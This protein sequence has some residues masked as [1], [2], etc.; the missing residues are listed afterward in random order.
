MQDFLQIFQKTLNSFDFKPHESALLEDPNGRFAYKRFFSK[1]EIPSNSDPKGRRELTF[2]DWVRYDASLLPIHLPN[3]SWYRARLKIRSILKHFRPGEL[4]FTNGSSSEPL[5]GRQSIVHKLLLHKWEI[6]PDCVDL[7]CSLAIRDHAFIRAAK[8]RVR[9]SLGA[10]Y[11]ETVRRIFSYRRSPD[12]VKQY[13]LRYCLSPR[14]ASRWGCVPKNNTIDR[15]IDLQPFCNML[16]QRAIGVGLRDLIRK[17]FDVDLLSSQSLHR[18]LIRESRFATIDL[19][20]ASDSNT[21]SL[22]QFLFPEWFVDLLRSACPPY[23]EGLDG[24]Y[25][26]TK[27]VSS[28]GNGFTFELMTLTLLTLVRDHDPETYV[29][30]DDIIAP[31]DVASQIISDL[32]S[33]GWVVNENKSFLHSPFRESCGGNF[34]DGYGYFRSYDFRY[35]QT[36][37]DCITFLNKCY[38]LREF[39]LFKQLHDILYRLIPIALRGPKPVV[40]T[41]KAGQPLD[42]MGFDSWVFSKKTP[43]LNNP[44][45][46]EP[47]AR[48]LQWDKWFCHQSLI[49]VPRVSVA[50]RTKL[51][52]SRDQM[53]FLQYLQAGRVSDIV[54]TGRGDWKTVTMVSNGL[55]SSR[56]KAFRG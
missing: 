22:V 35:P 21:W 31:N 34:L 36:A 45:W 51:K 3:G 38:L 27:K 20:N 41:G 30:G 39:P 15:A 8:M 28:M 49:W 26:I 10:E 2:N 6:S 23:T 18:S 46:F 17:E 29:F 32:L 48:D 1:F 5:H 4:T 24:D 54:F 9:Q 55:H 56:A 37:Q 16:V 13:L 43:L 47:Y 42:P 40:E 12:D 44:S 33:A 7:F 52:A 25:Y 19:K 50:R 11:R 53:L 14:E